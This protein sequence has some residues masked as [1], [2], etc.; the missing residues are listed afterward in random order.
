VADKILGIGQYGSVD[1]TFTA[2]PY[3]KLD[4]TTK[5]TL[6]TNAASMGMTAAE[7]YAGRG[8]VNASGYFGDSWSSSKNLTDAEYSA[9]IN[10]ARATGKTG[11]GI[12]SAINAA[13]AKKQYDEAIK[14][15]VDPAKAASDYN[16]AVSASN[17]AL[18]LSVPLMTD[19][20]GK[21]I[22]SSNS[23]TPINFYSSS[24]GTGTST[25]TGTGTGTGTTG[26]LLAPTIFKNTLALFF[27]PEEM[28]KPWVDELYKSV[29]TFYKTGATV[30]E[31]FNLTLQ[32]VRN[33]P[34]MAEFTKRFKGIYDLVDLKQ[35][36]KAVT[37]PTIAEYFATQSKMSDILKASDLGELATE[38][39]LG[40]VIGKAVPVS[41][42]AE[43]ITQAFDRIDLAP[44]QV[45]KTISTFYPTLTRTQL[46]KALITGEKGA[47]QLAK[48]IAGYEVLSAAEQ[49]KLA[50]GN[51]P[52]GVTVERA[53]D[54]A[55][56]GETFQ[57]ALGKFGRV[58]EILPE[59]TKLAGISNKTALS[60]AQ[61]ENI[62]FRE[63]VAERQALEDL[64]NEE[65]ARYSGKPGTI[66][67][68]SFASQAR[69]A[70]LI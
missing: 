63:S 35:G 41:V 44:A 59:A 2:V 42:F 45:K 19:S 11:V 23:G 20:A 52:G 28:A 3:A 55:A 31:A 47:K 67:S 9:A 6:A 10:T 51:L 70:G 46:A 27:G 21:V 53:T 25:G 38:E 12:G 49:Q 50:A 33:K 26:P 14:L 54:L 24:S 64:A 65:L 40:D 1:P 60:Q 18:G 5:A 22:S 39:F 69:G 36:G 62:V 16:A 7:Y 30:D 17:A 56:G 15:G 66:G 29:S 48:E 68:K 4:A 13:T 34:N 8:G 61:I 58:A 32:D 37:V 43:R 57:S